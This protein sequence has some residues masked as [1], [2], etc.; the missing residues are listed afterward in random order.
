[1]VTKEEKMIWVKGVELQ[2]GKKV[3]IQDNKYFHV[4]RANRTHNKDAIRSAIAKYFQAGKT[5]IEKPFQW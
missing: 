3:G 5:G 2:E 1:M 4:P